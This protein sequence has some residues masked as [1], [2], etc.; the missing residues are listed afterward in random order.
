MTK[1]NCVLCQEYAN[2]S[3]EKIEADRL[4]IEEINRLCDEEA[5]LPCTCPDCTENYEKN[6]DED[7]I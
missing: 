3:P 4:F 5:L 1:C 2:R 6:Y 7:M